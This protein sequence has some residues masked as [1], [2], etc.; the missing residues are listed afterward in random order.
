[1]NFLRG[2]NCYPN[3]TVSSLRAERAGHDSVIPIKCRQ[4]QYLL[5]VYICAFE[6]IFWCS[7]LW[8]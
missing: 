5:V 4:F 8:I 2:K 1:M 7:P 3:L 6:W